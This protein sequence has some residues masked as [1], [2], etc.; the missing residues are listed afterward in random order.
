MRSNARI[1]IVARGALGAIGLGLAKPHIANFVQRNS[2][3]H[4]GNLSVEAHVRFLC[5]CVAIEQQ[6][7]LCA[8]ISA[9]RIEI[10]R[11]D[12]NARA[13]GGETLGMKAGRAESGKS[14]IEALCLRSF[15]GL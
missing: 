12:I 6:A 3:G 10:E 5:H 7:H 14:G 8:Q 1:G 2:I 11:A 13:I 15:R 4:I 9:A